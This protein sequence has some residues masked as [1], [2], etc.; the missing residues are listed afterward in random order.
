MSGCKVQSPKYTVTIVKTEQL[1]RSYLQSVNTKD[2]ARFT[3]APSPSVASTLVPNM[4][5]VHI[6]MKNWTKVN[7]FYWN[8][9]SSLPHIT[10][11]LPYWQKWYQG[12][13]C[14]YDELTI[15]T[16]FV[17]K[18]EVMPNSNVSLLSVWL[19]PWTSG[20]RISISESCNYHLLLT[21]FWFEQILVTVSDNFSQ[22]L[23]RTTIHYM[24][25]S[26]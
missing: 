11:V 20:M 18:F 1:S 15:Y 26:W 25:W 9:S 8:V 17:K 24:W 4:Y 12:Y 14:H 5:C 19:S 21:P 23:S 6:Q 22:A 10:S 2:A 3:I 7:W 13:S 16:N